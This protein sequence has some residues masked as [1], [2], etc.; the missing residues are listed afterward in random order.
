[1]FQSYNPNNNRQ[2]NYGQQNRGYN[3]FNGQQNRGYNNFNG[4]QNRGYSQNNGQQNQGYA[5]YLQNNS[6]NQQGFN[7]RQNSSGSDI[8]FQNNP[9][10]SSIDP[11][12]LK[13]IMEIKEQSKNRSME[14]LVP[15]IMKVNQELNRR[16]MNFT[17]SETELLMEVIEESLSPAEKQK[18]NMLKG[19]MQ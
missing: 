3:N 11:M 12:K 10:L 2:A 7:Q 9:K 17:K 14:E 18:F 19:F 1:M 13:I 8:Q 16:N 15:Q 6:H 5:Q 4:Q